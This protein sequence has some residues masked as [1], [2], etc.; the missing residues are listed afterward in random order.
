MN[1]KTA[2]G[3]IRS[4]ATTAG[5]R[6]GV[7]GGDVGTHVRPSD[8]RGPPRHRVCAAT[9][10]RTSRALRITVH[11]VLTAAGPMAV[12]PLCAPRQPPG[13]GWPSRGG[14]GP[15]PTRSRGGAPPVANT[16]SQCVVEFRPPAAGAETDGVSPDALHDN[17]QRVPNWVM[18][19]PA[20]GAGRDVGD[21]AET[22]QS[23]MSG[24][25][26]RRTGPDRQRCAVDTIFYGSESGRRF[27]KVWS[28]RVSVAREEPILR[29]R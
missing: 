13:S 14:K 29:S 5:K 15:T 21:T 6:Y 7:L 3:E 25:R 28:R 27:V 9:A 4:R 22:V 17:L 26:G 24:A 12:M 1:R 8:L 20:R 19:G 18:A 11:R 10:I 2:R 16:R 23:E